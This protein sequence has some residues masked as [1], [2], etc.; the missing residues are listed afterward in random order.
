MSAK[1]GTMVSGIW[2]AT[3]TR[4]CGFGLVVFRR[5]R[6]GENRCLPTEQGRIG[7]ETRKK[8]GEPPTDTEHLERTVCGLNHVDDEV[9][10]ECWAPNSYWPLGCVTN[11]DN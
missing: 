5:Q 3:T 2:S 1:D 11:N 4:R 6:D 9:H 7:G 8:D 10:A